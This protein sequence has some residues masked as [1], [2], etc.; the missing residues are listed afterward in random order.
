MTTSNLR[1]AKQRVPVADLALELD[2]DLADLLLLVRSGNPPAIL[3]ADGNDIIPEQEIDAIAEQLRSSLSAGV[4]SKRE[5]ESRTNIAFDSLQPI[6]GQIADELIHYD[7]HVCT[8]A[9]DKVVSAQA[10]DIMN[11]VINENKY[12]D[13]E[14]M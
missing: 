12:V 10:L 3:S 9:Y 8:H 14:E 6:L 2:V 5:Q 13:S 4:V 7:D 11:R 1:T